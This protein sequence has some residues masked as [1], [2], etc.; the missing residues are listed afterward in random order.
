MVAGPGGS[1]RYGLT[2]SDVERLRQLQRPLR[3]DSVGW[4]RPRLTACD[5][6]PT[7]IRR[8]WRGRSGRRPSEAGCPIY[9]AASSTGT[10]TQLRVERQ[11]CHSRR[12]RDSFQ[13]ELRPRRI[14]VR[15]DPLTD[16]SRKYSDHES[17][18]LESVLFAQVDMV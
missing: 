5:R 7:W 1:Y 4:A 16:L 8:G 18:G 13:N 17:I 2:S 9:R 11:R 14:K 6:E 3:S 15:V 12:G 10:T